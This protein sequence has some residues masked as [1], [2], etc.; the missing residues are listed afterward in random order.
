MEDCLKYIVGAH[1][2]TKVVIYHS[3][4]QDGIYSFNVDGNTMISK[5]YTCWELEKFILTKI[6]FI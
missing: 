6:L 3:N 1:T 4:S 2:T 5:C